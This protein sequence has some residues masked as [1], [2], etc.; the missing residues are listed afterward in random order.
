MDHPSSFLEFGEPFEELTCEHAD[1]YEDSAWVCGQVYFAFAFAKSM[2]MTWRS[3]A[4]L[5]LVSIYV[6]VSSRSFSR[7]LKRFS[8]CREDQP[9][10]FPSVIFCVVKISNSTISKCVWGHY[11]HEYFAEMC[12]EE[13]SSLIIE[14][15]VKRVLGWLTWIQHWEI[16]YQSWCRYV[17]HAPIARMI[18][19]ET[20]QKPGCNMVTT[21]T[22]H[23]CSTWLPQK[24]IISR[25]VMGST[26]YSPAVYHSSTPFVGN[27]CALS[28]FPVPALKRTLQAHSVSR[29]I[30]A[31]YNRL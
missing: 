29:E 16:I 9:C 18:T 10:S 23:N 7:I 24:R 26:N 6:C 5:V 25:D 22:N 13:I 8:V 3:A 4:R 17:C 20:N 21:G 15:S 28:S 27:M 31:S 1:P 12:V 14:K 30:C 2:L 19:T 11:R